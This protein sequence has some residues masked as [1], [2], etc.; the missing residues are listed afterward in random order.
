[1]LLG[2]HG[3]VTCIQKR[4][5]L[6]L[7]L[8]CSRELPELLPRNPPLQS[9][10]PDVTILGDREWRL[11]GLAAEIRLQGDRLQVKA[12]SPPLEEVNAEDKGVVWR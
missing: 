1:M 12:K 8:P 2:P 7:A 5:H 10:P 11:L 6:A 3:C 4:P 9:A